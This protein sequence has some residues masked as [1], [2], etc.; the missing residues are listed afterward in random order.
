MVQTDNQWLSGKGGKALVRGVSETGGPQREH[1]PQ[2]LAGG[3]Q[4][5]N[6]IIGALPHI[7]DPVRGR[8]RSRMCKDAAV[9]VVG[10]VFLGYFKVHG[11]FL[12]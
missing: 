6:E 8:E 12:L 4:K 9:T 5:I 7:A 3:F 2:M 1:L 10:L 11:C